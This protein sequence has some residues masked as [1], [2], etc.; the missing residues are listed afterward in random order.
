MKINPVRHQNKSQQQ[1]KSV[2]DVIQEKRNNDLIKSKN[3]GFVSNILE[4]TYL[5]TKVKTKI[6]S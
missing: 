5:N 3:E 1:I 4:Q 2:N 6:Y